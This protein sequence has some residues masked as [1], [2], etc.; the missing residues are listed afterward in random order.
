V[1]SDRVKNVK[2][3]ATLGITSQAK[4]MKKQGIDI[5][6]FGA[7]EPDFDTPAYIKKAAIEA[8]KSGKTKYTPSVGTVELRETIC[9][10]LF[11]FNNLDYAPEDIIVSNGAKHSLYNIFQAICNKDDEV[12]V[13]AP[14]WVSYVEMIVLAQARPVI[15]DTFASEGFKVTP[16][17]L[18]G[19]I[20]DKTRAV[21]INS[22]S[23]P[24]GCL[25]NK[26]E[27]SAIFELLKGRDIKII[28]DEIYDRLIYDGLKSFSF[29]SLGQQAKDMAVIVNGVSKTYSMTGWRIGYMASS[30]KALTKAITNLQD[31]SS[32]NPCSISQEAALVAIGQEDNSVEE[33]KAQFEKRRNYMVSR[34][35]A[36][37]RVS[38]LKPQGAFYCFVDLSE[39]GKDTINIANCLL[40]QA[41]VAVVPGE[42]F[43][44]PGYIRLS[45][46]TSMKNIEEGL[47]RIEK[48]LKQ[49]RKRY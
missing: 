48:W 38:C 42:G 23:N 6:S 30:D 31:H 8:I 27:L 44:S 5:I 36:M 3:S 11:D 19:F 26:Q 12:I 15:V 29:A 10:R 43:G 25:Y 33:M 41:R 46:A 17:K 4:A 21:I 13:L 34:I 37:K 18:S 28:S 40:S 9:K 14:Y 7:G 20:T 49:K 1:L 39:I 24:T 16:D 32:S 35:E 47:D 2:P 45:F 22:P